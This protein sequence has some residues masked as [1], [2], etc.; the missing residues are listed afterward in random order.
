MKIPNDASFIRQVAHIMCLE[1][2]DS[3]LVDDGAQDQWQHTTSEFIRIANDVLRERKDP[4]Y[5]PPQ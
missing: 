4:N 1:A 5:K 3:W 2:G